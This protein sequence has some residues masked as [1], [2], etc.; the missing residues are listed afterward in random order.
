MGRVQLL[1]TVLQRV[2][3]MLSEEEQQRY[4][5]LFAPYLQGHAGHYVDRLKKADLPEHLQRIGEAVG[6]L[7]SELEGAYGEQPTYHVLARVFAEHFRL[8]AEGLQVKA[9]SE[10]SAGSL[11]SPDD[12]EATYREKR[13]QGQR[14]YMVNL[15]ETCDPENPLQPITQAAVAPNTTDD[16]RLLGEVLP[17]LKAHTGV[18]EVI[19]DGGYGSAENDV[20]PAAHQVTLIQTAI[21]G[22]SCSEPIPFGQGLDGGLWASLRRV[23]RAGALPGEPA[24]ALGEIAFALLERSAA[25]SGTA[26]A[27][28]SAG[29]RK[30]QPAGGGRSPG[31]QRETSLSGRESAGAGAL[32]GRLD[33][34]WIGG[35]GQC[36]AVALLLAGWSATEARRKG[37]RSGTEGAVKRYGTVDLFSFVFFCQSDSSAALAI[38]DHPCASTP[39]F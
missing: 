7:L 28:P 34:D 9:G 12:L 22:E 30:A 32:P 36:A 2:W 31:A 25:A 20:L 11:Q 14:G 19:T 18:K 27:C 26:A 39:S 29:G 23:Y 16:S 17:E 8:E 35:D 10:L 15:S 33:G 1:V 6:R 3:R 5:K 13:G 38:L 21:G 4:G 24:E 37:A